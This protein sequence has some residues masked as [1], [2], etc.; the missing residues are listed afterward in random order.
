MKIRH[1]NVFLFAYVRKKQY[2]CSRFGGNN[3]TKNGGKNTTNNGSN[4]LVYRL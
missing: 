2:L 4:N 3:T 1:K